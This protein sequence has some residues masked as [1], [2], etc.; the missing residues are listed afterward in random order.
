[1][2]A[3]SHSPPPSH[4][5]HDVIG[6]PQIAAKAPVFFE[7]LAGG[8]IEFA[9]VLAQGFGIHAALRADAAIAR[10]DLLAQIAGVGAQLP[11]MHARRAAKSEATLG[12]FGAAPAAQTSPPLRHKSTGLGAARAHTRS[13]YPSPRMPSMMRARDFALPLRMRA[14]ARASPRVTRNDTLFGLSG[15]G[16]PAYCAHELDGFEQRTGERSHARFAACRLFARAAR[17]RRD[18]RRSKDSGGWA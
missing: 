16:G 10:E 3:R 12:N 18:R 2:L 13:S 5:R 7:L 1:M 9:L 15:S 4:D 6:V 11:L 17:P 8:V 14:C